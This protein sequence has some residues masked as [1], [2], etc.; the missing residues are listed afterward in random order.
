MY[1]YQ[2]SVCSS[3]EG[4]IKPNPLHALIFHFLY[5]FH[6][7]AQVL[8]VLIS[9]NR[10][11]KKSPFRSCILFFIF[12]IYIKKGAEIKPSSDFLL[13]NGVGEAFPYQAQV[14]FY[15]TY[16]NFFRLQLSLWLSQSF[17]ISMYSVTYVGI[18]F[19]LKDLS[20]I[21]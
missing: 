3:L 5:I 17:L 8:V 2:V 12:F 10:L 11:S 13:T 9:N 20:A 16:V 14:C 4:D 19:G 21:Q 1:R 6:L 18:P 7:N 15:I